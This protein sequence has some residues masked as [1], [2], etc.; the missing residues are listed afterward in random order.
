MEFLNKVCYVTGAGSGIGKATALAFAR[1]GA[2]VV[3]CDINAEGASQTGKEIS[4]MGG[5]VLCLPLNI[6]RPDEVER[7]IQQTVERF[8]RLDCAANIAGIAGPVSKRIHE[9]PEEFWKQQIEVNL[10]GTWYCLKYQL[11]Q[12]LVNG[13]GSI[14]NLSSAAGLIAQ[15][16]NSPY[17]ASKH[18]V[19]GLTRTAAKEYATDHI[20]VN[21]VCP[22]AIET[23]MIMEGRRKLA[24]NPE[25][26]QAAIDFQ[27]MKRMGTPQEIANVIL[28]LCSEKSS[29]ITGVA[30][31]ADGGALA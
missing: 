7:S 19:V 22:T 10:T 20:R 31:A 17:A 9:Y 16:E 6:A 1:D 30:F 29:F 23:P 25:A 12:M 8:G 24:H 2:H 28:W 26:R 3:V 13:G 11:A 4:D 18:G 15:P 27:A 14:V 21:A 5:E